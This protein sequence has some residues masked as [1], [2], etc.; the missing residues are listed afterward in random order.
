MES[1]IR[2]FRIG[3]VIGGPKPGGSTSVLVLGCKRLVRMG[4]PGCNVPRSLGQH[5]PF[6]CIQYRDI[7][8]LLE[9]VSMSLLFLDLPKLQLHR[10]ARVFFRLGELLSLLPGA[11][12]GRSIHRLSSLIYVERF[13]AVAFAAALA[14]LGVLLPTFGRVPNSY[15]GR[16]DGRLRE[17]HRFSIALS[18]NLQKDGFQGS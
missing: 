10:I 16:H 8:S 14:V 2:I 11:R 7:L 13:T 5:P 6:C 1:V 18:E 4:S 9:R 12:L 15:V 3:S 17:I